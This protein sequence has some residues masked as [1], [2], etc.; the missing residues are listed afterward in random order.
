M[1]YVILRS[2]RPTWLTMQL[3]DDA[4]ELLR[5]R[6][7][8][9]RAEIDRT[10]SISFLARGSGIARVVASHLA[11]EP[12]A[13]EQ[14][15]DRLIATA[16]PGER[17]LFSIPSALVEYLGLTVEVRG[18]RMGRRTDDQMI[19]FLPAPEY[20]EFRAAEGAPMAWKGRSHGGMAHVYVAKATLPGPKA[21]SG[22]AD[23]ESHIETEDW[24]RAIEALQRG[25]AAPGRASSAPRLTK[26]F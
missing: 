16:R 4:A 6:G 9:A 7:P 2:I 8:P 21:L 3:P 25:P 22:L 15:R 11:R 10:G 14:L 18:P 24:T 20:Y 23:M 5:Y 19:W 26:A 12:L 13:I 17:R 1:E